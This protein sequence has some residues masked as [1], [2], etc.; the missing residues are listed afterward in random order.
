MYPQIDVHY[1]LPRA[2][3]ASQV[4]DA[5]KNQVGPVP[6]PYPSAVM[7]ALTSVP[8]LSYQGSLRVE[9]KDSPSGKPID[10]AELKKLFAT[11]GEVKLVKNQ[12]D[13]PECVDRMTSVCS[14]T[15]LG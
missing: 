5:D 7:D 15:F 4:C 8:S 9:L 10:D 3:E 13:H 2:E 11:V 12:P 14:K 1:S 6:S